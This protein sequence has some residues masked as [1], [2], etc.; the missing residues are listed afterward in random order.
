MNALGITV[1]V[2]LG[3]ILAFILYRLTVDIIWNKRLKTFHKTNENPTFRSPLRM[4]T[5]KRSMVAVSTV[6]IA[7]VLVVTDVFSLPGT[8]FDVETGNY[9]T[10]LTAKKASSEKDLLKKLD[11]GQGIQFPSFGFDFGLTDAAQEAPGTLLPPGVMPDTEESAQ[12]SIVGTNN[13]VEGVEESDIVKTD[14]NLILYTPTYKQNKIYV[15]DVD[16]LGLLKEL[17]P[18]E[19]FDLKI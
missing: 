10:L 18:I 12:K 15:F 14:G 8:V 11:Y 5:L 19:F 2:L 4:V 16:E 7:V 17:D 6:M 9:K 1:L 13:Q 3:L